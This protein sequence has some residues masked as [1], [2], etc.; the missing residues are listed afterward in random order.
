MFFFLFFFFFSPPAINPRVS[1]DG[2]LPFQ[3]SWVNG[4]GNCVDWKIIRN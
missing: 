2:K 1:K 4:R 3:V